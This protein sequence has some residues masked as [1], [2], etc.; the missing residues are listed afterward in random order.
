MQCWMDISGGMQSDIFESMAEG[1]RN[2]ACVVCFMTKKYQDSE[3][4]ALVRCHSHGTRPFLR[5]ARLTGV[6]LWSQELKF[7]KQ[8]GVPIVPVMMVTFSSAAA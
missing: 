7:A 3:N 1:V 2:A 5:S 6:V 8:S 4:C